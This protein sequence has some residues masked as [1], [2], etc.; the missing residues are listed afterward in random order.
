MA[1]KRKRLRVNTP[2][3]LERS[4]QRLRGSKKVVPFINGFYLKDVGKGY[5]RLHHRDHPNKLFANVYYVLPN[6][7]EHEGTIYF[8]ETPYS[9]Y[10]ELYHI[11]EVAEQKDL[12]VQIRRMVQQV[13]QDFDDQTDQE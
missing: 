7:F 2:E 6:K 3:N 4:L 13:D 12:N 8:V 1:Q 11:Y 9:S 10:D 5:F